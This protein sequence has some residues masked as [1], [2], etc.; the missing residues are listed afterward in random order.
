MTICYNSSRLVPSCNL[1]VL[2]RLAL[3]GTGAESERNPSVAGFI[4]DWTR[5]S[6]H[7]TLQFASA[8]WRGEPT[9][10]IRAKLPGNAVVREACIPFGLAL[11]S[12]GRLDWHAPALQRLVLVAC[13]ANHQNQV[14]SQIWTEIAA[15]NDTC[16]RDWRSFS[17]QTQLRE[18]MRFAKNEFDAGRP[19]SIG[20]T[21]RDLHRRSELRVR[22][23][24]AAPMST[25][26]LVSSQLKSKRLWAEPACRSHNNE[27]FDGLTSTLL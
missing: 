3:K 8:A 19:S 17:L 16:D 22:V 6:V 25:C 7:D 12:P 1:A 2:W 20:F 9:P 4:G 24:D 11:L 26:N 5:A 18:R 13:Q 23:R 15:D 27:V 21:K 10:H 14:N